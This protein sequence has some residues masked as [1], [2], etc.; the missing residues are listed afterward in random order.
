MARIAKTGGTKKG[1][2]GPYVIAA[3]VAAAAVLMGSRAL[4][5]W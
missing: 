2:A 5:W 1:P 3:F 4:G